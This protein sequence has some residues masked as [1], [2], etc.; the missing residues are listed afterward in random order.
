MGAGRVTASV[1]PASRVPSICR[2]LRG[3]IGVR[4]VGHDMAR[5]AVL[6]RLVYGA[7]PPFGYHAVVR[8]HGLPHHTPIRTLAGPVLCPPP[9]EALIDLFGAG[10]WRGTISRSPLPDHCRHPV[11]LPVFHLSLPLR[12]QRLPVRGQGQAETHSTRWRPLRTPPASPTPP[13][14]TRG[15]SA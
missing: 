11:P 7:V 5:V 12:L 9:L 15:L 1:G 10:E 6:S 4:R 14:E 3:G 13:G 8:L 2:K